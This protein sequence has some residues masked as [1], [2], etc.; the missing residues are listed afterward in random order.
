MLSTDRCPSVSGTCAPSI[1]LDFGGLSSIAKRGETSTCFVARPFS[2]N[3]VQPLGLAGAYRFV[4]L[5][6]VDRLLLTDVFFDAHN[7]LFRAVDGQLIAVR[8]F[9]NFALRK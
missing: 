9:G 6:N 7:Y 2:A 3:P 1:S 5:Q 8:C 4:N